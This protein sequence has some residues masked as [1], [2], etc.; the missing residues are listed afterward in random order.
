MPSSQISRRSYLAKRLLVK[1]GHVRKAK[2]H[3]TFLLPIL[4]FFEEPSFSQQMHD[5]M[6]KEPACI[7]TN[8]GV[9][10]GPG[11]SIV[12]SNPGTFNAGNTTFRWQFWELNDSESVSPLIV[13]MLLTLLEKLQNAH[14]NT[15]V[16]E[17]AV[18]DEDVPVE[19]PGEEETLHLVNIGE[20][21]APLSEQIEG[22]TRSDDKLL[23][24]MLLEQT[25]HEAIETTI[26]ATLL[27]ES[28]STLGHRLSK[29]NSPSLQNCRL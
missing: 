16:V 21:D 18:A 6:V 28:S 26:E 29:H 13:S 22:S 15:E 14:A 20:L 27:Q 9:D 12:V 2:L 1:K 11:P 3:T 8:K 5:V 17:P 24:D 10:V 7:R 23:D 19:S 4:I 25:H